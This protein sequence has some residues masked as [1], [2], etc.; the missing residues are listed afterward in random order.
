MRKLREE[1]N[2]DMRNGIFQAVRGKDRKVV[3]E[4]VFR[5]VKKVLRNST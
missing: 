2:E 4:M 5:V 3:E 1:N